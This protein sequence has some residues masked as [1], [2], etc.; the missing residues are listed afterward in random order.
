MGDRVKGKVAIVTGAGSAAAG[1]GNGK[2]S[3]IVYAREGARVMVVDYRL[4]AAEETEKIIKEEGGDCITFEADVSKSGDCRSMVERCIEVYGSI[5]ILHNNVGIALFGGP[6]ELS[7]EDWDRAMD[8]NVKSMF[9]ICKY[10]LPYM[11]KQGS[12]SI[13]NISSVA[14]IR[15]MAV[16][17][18]SYETTKTAIIGLTR[19]IAIQYA[20]K[21]IRANAIL[22]GYM[23][24]PMIEASVKQAYGKDINEAHRKRDAMCPTGH[25]G[26]AWDVAY[27][28][29]Y[30]A[31]DEAKYV[32]AAN[33]V[34]DGGITQTH[35]LWPA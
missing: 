12:G 20:S 15:A 6:V 35:R 9:L 21:G 10:A 32:T 17:A 33:F 27:M 25:Q 1:I 31:S 16:P 4:D 13:I 28:A 2:A 7:E 30:L 18:I 24:T 3:A 8:V 23:R 26:E 34:V 5:D 22:P 14:G 19:D 11:E 29:L